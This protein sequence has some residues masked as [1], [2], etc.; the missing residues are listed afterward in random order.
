MKASTSINAKCLKWTSCQG[1]RG[2]K[3]YLQA[4]QEK[5]REKRKKVSDKNE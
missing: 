3:S 2:G 1:I 4:L 5:Q